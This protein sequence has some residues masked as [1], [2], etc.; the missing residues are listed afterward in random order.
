[1]LP[2]LA[3]LALAGCQTASGPLEPQQ[4]PADQL[5][6]YVGSTLDVF[7]RAA[8]GLHP[9]GAR[10]TPEGR[11]LLYEGDPVVVTTTTLP[12]Y[13]PSPRTYNGSGFGAAANGLTAALG[14]VP[15]VSRSRIQKCRVYLLAKR[16]DDA[17]RSASWRI[18]QAELEGAC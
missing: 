4:S 17:P 10:D 5:A 9:V 12:P 1:M 3:A 11:I 16:I 2:L 18:E 6:S 13:V 15:G 7:E 8:V 14:T